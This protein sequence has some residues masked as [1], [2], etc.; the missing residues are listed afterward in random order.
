MLYDLCAHWSLPWLV[1]TFVTQPTMHCHNRYSTKYQ[2]SSKQLTQLNSQS[3]HA[4]IFTCQSVLSSQTLLSGLTKTLDIII[5]AQLQLQS[6]SRMQLISL[7]RMIPC[8]ISPSHLVTNI[9]QFSFIEPMY[10]MIVEEYGIFMGYVGNIWGGPRL[11]NIA[12]T[13]R[14][15]FGDGKIS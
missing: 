3:T 5:P 9:V 10:H 11:A 4:T 8:F 1:G 6:I 2:S 13:H 7:A 15:N 14:Q 12:H